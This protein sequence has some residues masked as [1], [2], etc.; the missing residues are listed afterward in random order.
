M[1]SSRL[2]KKSVPASRRSRNFRKTWTK[3]NASTATLATSSRRFPKAGSL[4]RFCASWESPCAP[5]SSLLAQNIH[6]IA[7]VPIF[8]QA[9][10]SGLA[11]FDDCRRN[12]CANRPSWTPYGPLQRESAVRSSA[13]S[14]ALD[15]PARGGTHPKPAC[16][17]EPHGRR[18]TG[19]KISRGGKPGKA[20]ISCHD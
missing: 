17:A 8:V 9:S 18:A 6:S 1:D 3:S 19:G 14:R 16:G 13:S 10:F 7:L 5:R 12:A 11:G 2:S 15:A 20:C 4:Q